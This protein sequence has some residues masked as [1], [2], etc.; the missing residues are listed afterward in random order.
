MA[1]SETWLNPEIDSDLFKIEGYTFLRK[2]RGTRGGGVGLFIK[3]EIKYSILQTNNEI[4]QL[5][6]SVKISNVMYLVGVIYRPPNLECNTFLNSFENTVVS[7]LPNNFK[8][9][10]CLGDFNIDQLQLHNPATK[11]FTNTMDCLDIEQIIHEPTRTTA[12]SS[13]LI[14]LILTTNPASILDKGVIAMHNLSD[15]DLVYCKINATIKS[16]NREIIYRDYKNFS[17]EYFNM[18]L[19]SLPI[20]HVTLIENLEEKVAFLNECLSDLYN[21]Q[22]PEKKC[23][24]KGPYTPWVTY[25]LK[26]IMKQR[27]KARNKYNKNKTAANWEYYKNIR[28]FTNIAVKREKKAY[29]N[30][31]IQNGDISQTWAELKKINVIHNKKVNIPESLQNPD[32]INNFFINSV[33]KLQNIKKFD[34]IDFYNSNTKDNINSDFCFSPVDDSCV[35]KILSNIS[36]KAAGD[37]GFNITF[38]LLCCPYI[39]PIITH[40]VNYCLENSVFPNQWKIGIVKPIPKCNIVTEYKDLRP[41]CIL[42]VLS[43]ILEKIIESQL[44][45]HIND[46]QIIPLY[47]SGFR[48]HHSCLTALLNISDDIITSTDNGQITALILLDFSKAF[49]TLDHDILIAVL[50]F[51]GLTEKAISLLSNYLTGRRQRVVINNESSNILEVSSG[52]PQGSI[53]GPLLYTVYTCNFFSYITYCRYHFYADDTQLYY[54]FDASDVQQASDNINLDLL[55]ITQ[56]AAEHSLTINSTK[57]ALTVFGKKNVLGEVR[58]SINIRVGGNLLT[59]VNEVKNLG[60]IMDSDIKFKKQISE[61]IRKAYYNLKILYISKDMLN[62]KLRA[63]LCESLV[64]SQFN[65]CDV[66]YGFCIDKQDCYRIQKVQNSCLRFIYGIKKWDHVSYKLKEL[67]WLNMLDRRKYHSLCFFHRLILLKSPQYLYNKIRF[68]TDIHNINIRKKDMLSMPRH[69]SVLYQRSFSYNIV[70][71]YNQ[72]DKNMKLMPMSSFKKKVKQL[73]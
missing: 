25:N 18:H 47:Q 67:N 30:Y 6:V 10:Y 38:I 26:Q 9:L 3:N 11:L 59:A 61:M 58:N 60:V 52:V 8:N 71:L 68:R 27:D 64:L 12:S 22:I 28:N 37:D 40:I 41:V 4:E 53:L 69:K 24:I 62:R 33:P 34:V 65:Y 45:E 20:F 66:L 44:R 39:V 54:S 43:K 72:I 49:D 63:S 15:H 50:H 35:T 1:I 31:K 56:A 42:P 16:T 46:K 17:H 32:D 57:S 51:I 7:E 70:K 73:F 55:S 29:L 48:P 21:T 2:D 19:H 13:T 23:T 36:T 14:D 5:W